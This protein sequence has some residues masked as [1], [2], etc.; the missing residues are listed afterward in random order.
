MPDKT[1]EQSEGLSRREQEIK[2]GEYAAEVY[3]VNAVTAAV[4]QQRFFL[5]GTG[6]LILAL[7]GNARATIGNPAASGRNVYVASVVLFSNAAGEASLF[8]NPTAGLPAT[9]ARTHL[10]A[11]VGGAQG[12]AVFKADTS[13]TTALS[14]GID[15]G[16]IMPFPVSTR[17]SVDMPPLVLTPG[18]TLG[19]NIPIGAASSRSVLAVYWFEEDV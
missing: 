5:A 14:G 7:A 3:T 1:W 18:V 12:V 13:T 4:A 16:L 15:T 10:N 17:V 19:I 9:G 6:T 11:I 2:T 8:V